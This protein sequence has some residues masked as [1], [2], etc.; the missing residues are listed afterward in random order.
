[1]FGEKLLGHGSFLLSGWGTCLVNCNTL[2][3]PCKFLC[4]SAEH[5]LW[6][7]PSVIVHIYREGT[8]FEELMTGLLMSC[9]FLSNEMTR[10]FQVLHDHGLLYVVF[11]P[12][13]FPLG[14]HWNVHYM[15]STLNDIALCKYECR[16]Q[17][18]EYMQAAVLL[19]PFSS[20]VCPQY[21]I[22]THSHS[23]SQ[24]KL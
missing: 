23:I 24:S 21:I 11:L 8:N 12:I 10:M 6:L 16:G 13:E 22:S 4:V 19:V 18:V 5:F 17:M 2:Y 7:L 14:D 9:Y 1:M 15:P 20:Y 3:V